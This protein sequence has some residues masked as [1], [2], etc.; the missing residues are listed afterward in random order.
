MQASGDHL[1]QPTRY[2]SLWSWRHTTISRV[3]Y[4]KLVCGAAELVG[5]VR[6]ASLEHLEAHL[7]PARKISRTWGF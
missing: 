3:H 6:L 1:R 2:I 5:V 4:F 7:M